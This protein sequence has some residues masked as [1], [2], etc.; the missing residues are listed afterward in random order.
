MKKGHLVGIRLAKR[1]RLEGRGSPAR[2]VCG[3]SSFSLSRVRKIGYQ[4][5]QYLL[6][7]LIDQKEEMFK[8]TFLDLVGG[9]GSAQG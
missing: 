5:R 6:G 1:M 8:V 9:L 2:V 3:V 4:I 7:Q